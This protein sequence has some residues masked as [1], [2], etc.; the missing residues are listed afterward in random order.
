M[1]TEDIFQ[2]SLIAFS[3]FALL[4]NGKYD[5]EN[6]YDG[7]LWLSLLENWLNLIV[8]YHQIMLYSETNV[9]QPTVEF[10][11]P[12]L[13]SIAKKDNDHDAWQAIVCMNALVLRLSEAEE[14]TLEKDIL[15]VGAG[16]A[17]LT[18]KNTYT[19]YDEHYY[20]LRKYYYTHIK[21]L[22]QNTE[23]LKNELETTQAELD[24]TKELLSQKEFCLDTLESQWQVQLSQL[25]DEIEESGLKILKG[26]TEL[27]DQR[28][29]EWKIAQDKSHSLEETLKK[30]HEQQKKLENQVKVIWNQHGSDH[31][32][33][34]VH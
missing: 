7:S 4:A 30:S 6:I 25:Q 1:D 16:A 32:L 18:K 10:S 15:G 5:M 14:T 24:D 13:Y 12:D 21:K 8:L 9:A 3:R 2:P 11:V 33:I 26:Q 19:E 27:F 17:I 20:Y 28:E 22:Q 29:N 31:Y 34:H 23:T